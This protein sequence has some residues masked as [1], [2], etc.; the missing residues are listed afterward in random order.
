MIPQEVDPGPGAPDN[1]EEVSVEDK[2]EK[3]TRD[4]IDGGKLIV[5]EELKK[6]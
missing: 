3:R 2:K 4:S 1:T 5:N 6:E